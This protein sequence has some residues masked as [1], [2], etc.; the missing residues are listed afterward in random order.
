MAPLAHIFI[1]AIAAIGGIISLLV[2]TKPWMSYKNG[3]SLRNGDQ[4]PLGAGVGQRRLL[5]IIDPR[6]V[7]PRVPGPPLPNLDG[8]VLN[9]PLIRTVF[10]GRKDDMKDV[11]VNMWTKTDRG[12]QTFAREAVYKINANG[13]VGD[14]VECGVWMG[15][16]SMLMVFENMKSDATRHF[17]LFDTFD[18]MPE[19]DRDMDGAQAKQIYDD[20]T[21]N[22]RTIEVKRRKWKGAVI[23]K[24]WD[25][26]PL[27]VV[28]NNLQ[29]TGYPRE[30]FHFVKGKVEDTL[31]KTLLPEKIAI[32]RLDTDW[33]LSTKVEL[34]YMYSRLQSGGVL[35]VD[36]YCSWQGARTAIDE[37]F[38]DTL[39]LDASKISKQ[40]P[41]LVYWKP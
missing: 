27:D 26:G 22:V 24:K 41:C 25:Y 39:N 12:H 17:W 3:P 5:G 19:P 4:S 18:G 30:N 36:D 34:E 10:N 1:Q 9:S 31:P 40:P 38:K 29:Y 15:G 37:F 21:N 11:L 32:L 14:I 28:M 16:M 23:D 6:S 8:E 2:L 20:V 35:I 7:E 33:Y 13:I